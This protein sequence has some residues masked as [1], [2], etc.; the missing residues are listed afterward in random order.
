MRLSAAKR[1][2][3]INY[4]S[5]YL[6]IS[7]E[8]LC[9]YVR[10]FKQPKGFFFLLTPALLSLHQFS[11]N[12]LRWDH[13]NSR[14]VSPG[15]PHPFHVQPK[16]KAF[17]HLLP[18]GTCRAE[19]L[20]LQPSPPAEPSPSAAD[21]HFS[22]LLIGSCQFPKVNSSASLIPGQQKEG[23]SNPLGKRGL[24]SPPACS[25]SFLHFTPRRDGATN[26]FLSV[27]QK[28]WGRGGQVWL[29]GRRDWRP[30][31]SGQNVRNCFC[32]TAGKL[33]SLCRTLETLILDFEKEKEI[34][35]VYLSL[36]IFSL[37]SLFTSCYKESKFHSQNK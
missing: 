37:F 1:V 35:F 19:A 14:K 6:W 8:I 23:G 33:F 24:R 9:F 25:R 32:S 10:T 29:A 12:S 2:S 13:R 18:S 16:F 5:H 34:T 11:L 7:T 22:N 36:P 17:L 28:Q 20:L 4:A 27:H 31:K 15:S 21:S 3:G 26:N 30:A